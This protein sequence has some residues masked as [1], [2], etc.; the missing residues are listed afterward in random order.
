MSRGCL[1][2]VTIIFLI[3]CGQGGGVSDLLERSNAHK[4]PV[5]TLGDV[6]KE[7]GECFT[8]AAMRALSRHGDNLLKYYSPK[9]SV[10]IIKN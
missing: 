1:S 8:A 9:A 6:K 2:F 7:N 10:D 5:L 3:G 4:K